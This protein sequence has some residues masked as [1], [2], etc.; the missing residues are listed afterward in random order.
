MITR[1]SDTNNTLGSK[2]IVEQ[3]TTSLWRRYW[4]SSVTKCMEITFLAGN[5]IYVH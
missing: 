2:G 1:A 5:Y 3:E 4:K